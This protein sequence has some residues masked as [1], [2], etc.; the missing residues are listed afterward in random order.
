[1]HTFWYILE[2]QFNAIIIFFLPF[3]TIHQI[4]R[5]NHI[6]NRTYFILWL[7][8]D[9]SLFFARRVSKYVIWKLKSFLFVCRR[10][11]ITP[12][13]P[14]NGSCLFVLLFFKLL[15]FR[16][17]CCYYYIFSQSNCHPVCLVS[18]CSTF[19]PLFICNCVWSSH[20]NCTR[21][22]FNVWIKY[23]K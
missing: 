3:C 6:A 17:C 23:V 22:C 19:W 14:H 5:A 18:V 2:Q 12:W 13:L 1:M 9:F 7:V 16:C 21:F 11:Q 20:H 10:L 8:C 15:F 4:N